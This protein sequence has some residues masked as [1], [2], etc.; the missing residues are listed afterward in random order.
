MLILNFRE[1]DIAKAT[2]NITLI[3]RLK[4]LSFRKIVKLLSSLMKKNFIPHLI[5]IVSRD[6]G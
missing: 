3:S 1:M 4:S 5:I 2:M 6:P